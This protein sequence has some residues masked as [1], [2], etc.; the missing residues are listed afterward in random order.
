MVVAHMSAPRNTAPMCFGGAMDFPCQRVSMERT[1]K[2][3]CDSEA[4]RPPLSS[5]CRH[6]LML[7]R[8]PYTVTSDGWTQ[9]RRNNGAVPLVVTFIIALTAFFATSPLR[10]IGGGA[11]VRAALRLSPLY[12]A[13][14]PWCDLLDTLSLMSARQH[15][16]FLVT[17]LGSF[18]LLR[19]L[20]WIRNPRSIS[21]SRELAGIAS[22]VAVLLAIYAIGALLPRPMASLRLLNPQ[23]SRRRLS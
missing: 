1:W 19:S 20:Q 6:R 3:S 8:A 23:R 22:F 16:A 7:P 12:I 10:G 4:C 11:P 2:G 18:I 13:L 17:L 14:A 21:A 5:T 9:V 15:I